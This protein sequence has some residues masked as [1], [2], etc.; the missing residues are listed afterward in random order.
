MGWLQGWQITPH[1]DSG[2][3][4][5][6]KAYPNPA[7]RMG[8]HPGPSTPSHRPAAKTQTPTS[9]FLFSTESVAI[10]VVMQFPPRLSLRTLVIMEFLYGMCARCFSARAMIT[11]G[12]GETEP[13]LSRT[14]T[15]DRQRS[16]DCSKNTAWRRCKLLPL[17]WISNELLL[18]SMGNTIRSRVAEHEKRMYIYMCVYTYTHTHTHTCITGSFCCTAEIDRCL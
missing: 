1:R 10:M 18:Y 8:A 16:C 17:E 3:Y 12:Q 6:L 7:E 5:P 9:I 14:G 11:C 4:L 13:Q 15:S 2:G